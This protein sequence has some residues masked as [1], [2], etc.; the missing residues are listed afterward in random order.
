MVCEACNRTSKQ[1]FGLRLPHAITKSWKFPKLHASNVR[2]TL[3]Q[4]GHLQ[5]THDY[6]QQTWHFEDQYKHTYTHT[7]SHTDAV[8]GE[9]V[10]SD[11]PRNVSDTALWQCSSAASGRIVLS[12]WH[13]LSNAHCSCDMNWCHFQEIRLRDLPREILFQHG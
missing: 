7:H 8:F 2:H 3:C 6:L 5:L 12:T 1:W 9:S 13:R 4:Q 10:E 11:R